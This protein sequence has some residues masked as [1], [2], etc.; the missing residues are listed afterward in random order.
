MEV[1][2]SLISSRNGMSDNSDNRPDRPYLVRHLRSV[3]D[4]PEIIETQYDDR[5]ASSETDDAFSGT[6]TTMLPSDDTLSG[7]IIFSWCVVALFG[8]FFALLIAA[9]WQWERRH[10]NSGSNR[11]TASKALDKS[12]KQDTA[13][14]TLLLEETVDIE[15][16]A[17]KKTELDRRKSGSV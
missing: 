1:A 17:K 11:S 2:Q 4:S 15:D 8:F 14:P 13:R 9:H 6:T 16:G 5:N 10:N 7:V 3:L 12:K